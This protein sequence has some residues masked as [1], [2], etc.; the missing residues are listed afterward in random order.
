MEHSQKLTDGTHIVQKRETSRLYRDSQGR[1]RTERALENP[2]NTHPEGAR[3]IH[4]YD[5]VA[6]YSYTLDAHSH[7]AHR[8]ALPATAEAAAAESSGVRASTTST[9]LTPA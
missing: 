8:F 5:P 4:I 3:L 6:G 7:I 2:A 9:R 1:T